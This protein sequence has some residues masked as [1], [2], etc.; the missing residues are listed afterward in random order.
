MKSLE[1]KSCSSCGESFACGAERGEERCWCDHLPHLSL[2]ANEARDCFCPQC[3]RETIQ[4]L[5]CATTSAGAPAIKA[6]VSSQYW[7]VEGVHFYSEGRS[8]V[9]KPRSQHRRRDCCYSG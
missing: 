5:N 4:K 6:A 1:Q 2:V 3:L 8:V 7:P 9:Y